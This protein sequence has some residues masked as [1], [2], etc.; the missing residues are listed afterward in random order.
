MC[1]VNCSF[2]HLEHVV[3]TRSLCKTSR[4]IIFLLSNLHVNITCA[5]LYSVRMNTGLQFTPGNCDANA[6]S[7]VITS[8]L[9]IERTGSKDK[10]ICFLYRFKVCGKSSTCKA[11][12]ALSACMNDLK[13][14]VEHLARDQLPVSALKFQRYHSM[15]KKVCYKN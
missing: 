3:F 9:S 15:K 11:R 1:S 13:F 5:I 12:R 8:F 14:A 10:L 4:N 2:I 7:G 6:I